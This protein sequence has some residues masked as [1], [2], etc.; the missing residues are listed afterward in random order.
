WQARDGESVRLVFLLIS[1]TDDAEGHLETM[2]EIARLAS[3]DQ[4]REYLLSAEV[5][6]GVLRLVR[7]LSDG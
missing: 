6:D 7:K 5:P 3:N 2:A 1:P 4:N